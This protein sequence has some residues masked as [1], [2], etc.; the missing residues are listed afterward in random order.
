MWVSTIS[1]L[2][3]DEAQFLR[4]AHPSPPCQSTMGVLPSLKEV[5]LLHEG[6]STQFT[7]RPSNIPCKVCADG[8][9]QSKYNSCPAQ[10]STDLL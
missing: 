9:M 8:T 4:L 3:V 5:L 6:Q 2:L 10:L 1:K 7:D